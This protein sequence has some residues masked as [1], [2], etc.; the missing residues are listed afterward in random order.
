MDMGAEGESGH[1]PTDLERL[2]LERLAFLRV[3]TQIE[4]L[5]G[6]RNDGMLTDSEFEAV[7]A[8]LLHDES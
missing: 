3:L 5:V 1:V 7:K 4:K 2:A 8:R 6:L